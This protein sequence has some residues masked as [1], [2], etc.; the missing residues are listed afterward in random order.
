M[1]ADTMKT[2]TMGPDVASVEQLSLTGEGTK[3]RRDK[4]SNLRATEAGREYGMRKEDNKEGP[5][6]RSAFM[7]LLLSRRRQQVPLTVA[8]VPSAPSI[9][10]QRES[11]MARP[12]LDATFDSK[13]SIESAGL[14][15]EHYILTSEA[16]EQGQVPLFVV[17]PKPKV[18]ELQNGFLMRRPVVVFLHSTGRSK[19]MM[20]PH[21]Q[22][23]AQRGY[24]TAAIDAR[25]HGERATS[26]TSYQEALVAAWR[27]AEDFP[28]LYDNIWDLMKL[29]DYLVTR[30]DVDPTR[31]GITGV[32]LGGM[33][34]WLAGAM[35]TRFK[36]V[37]PLIGVQNFGWAVK[38]DMWQ[39]RV[40]SIP[41]VFEAA[42]Q[43]LQKESVDGDVV[44]K[45]WDRLVP[46]LTGQFDTPN[47]LP[48]IAPRPLCILN[49]AND[50]RCPAE[51]LVSPVAATA[52]AYVHAGAEAHF[53][54]ISEGNVGHATT[55]TMESVMSDWFDTFLEPR[56]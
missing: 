31:I 23:F 26:E 20:L 38:H 28:F 16:G 44:Q 24:L 53:K 30:P 27:T 15:K 50:L 1:A 22:A 17:A 43:D 5:A 7:D 47:T 39:A 32:S 41:H 12:Q 46:G 35:D 19:E 25:Y 54:Y 51:G 49:G 56:L 55:L 3:D 6:L 4:G 42:R 52:Q 11:S 2:A 21:M 14:E 8:P 13:V 37:V 48:A 40:S 18:E 9:S 34:S 45:V 36:V 10:L 33:H 29:V